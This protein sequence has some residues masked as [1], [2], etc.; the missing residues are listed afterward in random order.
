MV[1]GRE[2]AAKGWPAFAQALRRGKFR[3]E[4]DTGFPAKDGLVPKSP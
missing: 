2:A 1:V 3:S 4:P